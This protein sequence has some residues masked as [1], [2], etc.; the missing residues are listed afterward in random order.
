MIE[1]NSEPEG[2][3][4]AIWRDKGHEARR[5]QVSKDILCFLVTMV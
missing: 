1:I 3:N 4:L 2:H 5:K